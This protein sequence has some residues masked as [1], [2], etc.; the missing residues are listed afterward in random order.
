VD[1]IAVDYKPDKKELAQKLF[2]SNPTVLAS[3]KQVEVARLGVGE[4]KSLLL[5]T[6][7]FT[8]GYDFLHGTY[9]AGTLK[10][11]QSYGPS[12]G[13]T[14]AIPIYQSGNIRRQVAVARLQFESA[15]ID[16]EST[17]LQVNT[18]LQFA[19]TEFDNQLQL[20]MIERDNYA[21]AKENMMI[22]IRRLQLGQ[23]TA[24]EVRQ[25]QESYQQSLTRLTDFAYA[26]K[27][28]EI[29]LKQLLGAL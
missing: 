15:K 24:L 3:Q 16:F 7:D 28:A 27:V 19:L 5:P 14:L 4:Y 11:N 18:Q 9:G 29:R 12:L 17:K 21:L 26:A 8:A 6:L 1:T 2:D 13:G 25:A 20:L 10:M 22:S 23:T